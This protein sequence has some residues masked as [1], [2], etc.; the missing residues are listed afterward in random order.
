MVFYDFVNYR[1][2]KLMT[3]FIVIKQCGYLFYILTVVCIGKAETKF[4]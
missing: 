2:D 1:E 4:V 3:L